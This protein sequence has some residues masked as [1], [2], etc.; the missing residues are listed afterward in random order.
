MY[1]LRFTGVLGMQSVVNFDM[2]VPE[3]LAQLHSI[4]VADEEDANL[5]EHLEDAVDFIDDAVGSAGKVWYGLMVAGDV[6]S[7]LAF[8][9]SRVLAMVSTWQQ[10]A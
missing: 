8:M 6:L 5:L 3:G 2:E 10:P 1:R 4:H 9:S 7:R